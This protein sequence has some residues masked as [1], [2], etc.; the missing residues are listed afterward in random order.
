M[1][2][3][4]IGGILLLGTIGRLLGD[5]PYFSPWSNGQELGFNLA[6]IFIPV[7]GFWLCYKGIMESK[8]TKHE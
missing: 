1:A 2:K 5:D 6:Q 7:L 3:F 8:K 4:I